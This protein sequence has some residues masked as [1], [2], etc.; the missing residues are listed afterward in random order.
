MHPRQ[1]LS[2]VVSRATLQRYDNPTL[3]PNPGRYGLAVLQVLKCDLDHQPPVCFCTMVR[4]A[5]AVL[6]TGT[7]TLNGPA[8]GKTEGAVTLHDSTFATTVSC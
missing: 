6:L 7:V 8:A 3:P 2:R 5:L 4:P 1:Q